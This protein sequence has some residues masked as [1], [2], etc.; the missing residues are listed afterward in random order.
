[1]SFVKSTIAA[2]ALVLAMLSPAAAQNP[3]PWDI[4][5]RTAYIVMMDGRTMS[6]SLNDRAMSTLMRNAKRVAGG[7]VLIKSGGQLYMVNAR[8]MMFDREGNWMAMGGGG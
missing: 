1:M 2:G 7:T 3:E 8:K 4:R 5:E 6:V